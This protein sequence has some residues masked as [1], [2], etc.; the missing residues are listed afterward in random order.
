MSDTSNKSCHTV[1][2][3]ATSTIKRMCL[4]SRSERCSEQNCK[5]WWGRC[6]GPRFFRMLHEGLL[7]YRTK[8]HT[9]DTGHA[10][11]THGSCE[12][13]P[14]LCSPAL[15]NCPPNFQLSAFYFKVPDTYP[16]TVCMALIMI[17]T[18]HCFVVCLMLI[19]SKDRTKGNTSLALITQQKQTVTHLARRRSPQTNYIIALL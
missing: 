3:T 4:F 5:K 11:D 13:G 16:D 15:S 12:L 2:H 1:G 7:N 18:C 6:C 14:S 8:E 19:T 17:G 10:I 9:Q